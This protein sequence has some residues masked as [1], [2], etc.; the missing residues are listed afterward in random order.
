MLKS[1]AQ[2]AKLKQLEKDGKLEKGTVKRW[3]NETPNIKKLP[4]RLE[5]KK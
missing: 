5:K 2:L 4:E 1:R 3:K